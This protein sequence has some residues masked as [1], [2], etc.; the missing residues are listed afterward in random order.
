MLVVSHDVDMVTQVCKRGIVLRDGKVC[1]D[2]AVNDA[3]ASMQGN[4]A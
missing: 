4:G 3:V 2:G 1:F